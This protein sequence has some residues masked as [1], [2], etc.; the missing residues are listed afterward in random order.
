MYVDSELEKYKMTEE[1]WIKV[2]RQ[3]HIEWI[4]DGQP[5]GEEYRDS[6]WGN[7]KIKDIHWNEAIGTVES[8]F[9]HNAG[10]DW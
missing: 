1:F 6:I 9:H 7:I 5:N 3:A 2:K 4:R 10:G 8:W